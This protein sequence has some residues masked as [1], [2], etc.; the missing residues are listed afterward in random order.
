MAPELYTLKSQSKSSDVFAFGML[1]WE[2]ITR[3]RHTCGIFFF[4]FDFSEVK[5]RGTVR[6][7]TKCK[8]QFAQERGSGFFSFKKY[9]VKMDREYGLPQ[10]LIIWENY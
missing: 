2:V 10:Y 5:W 1:M 8:L 4:N 7:H 3:I 9:Y 6:T